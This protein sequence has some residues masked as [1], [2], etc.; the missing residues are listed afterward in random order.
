VALR[1]QGSDFGGQELPEDGLFEVYNLWS[2]GHKPGQENG[3]LDGIPGIYGHQPD[4]VYIVSYSQQECYD[5]K[6]R[7]QEYGEKKKFN[8]TA[9]GRQH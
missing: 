5:N 6:A 8:N 4:Y 2:N 1:E 7:I 3:R 9:A